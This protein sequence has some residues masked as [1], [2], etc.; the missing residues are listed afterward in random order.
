M[1]SS[2]LAPAAN[3]GQ[4]LLAR[5]N[6]GVFYKG[7]RTGGEKDLDRQVGQQWEQVVGAR[8]EAR[9]AEHVGKRRSGQ[10]IHLRLG[11]SQQ[12]GGDALLLR[13]VVNVVFDE[14]EV[15]RLD[16]LLLEAVLQLI[17]AHH[18][19]QAILIGQRIGHE[20]SEARAAI[21]TW[22]PSVRSTTAAS[23]MIGRTRPALRRSTKLSCSG[24]PAWAP[25]CLMIG[26]CGASPSTG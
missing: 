19:H 6:Q 1:L 15:I 8:G 21:R 20:L 13:Q 9:I 16:I 17:E 10:V 2:S 24:L 18:L 25:A 11:L 4:R 3:L 7:V 22:P 14:V 12:V 23:L 5:G 26:I